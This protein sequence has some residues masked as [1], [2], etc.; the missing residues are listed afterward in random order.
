MKRNTRKDP[1]EKLNRKANKTR[2]IFSTYFDR[3]ALSFE[4]LFILQKNHFSTL[5]VHKRSL[6]DV[7]RC[8]RGSGYWLLAFA[9][10]QLDKLVS[11]DM[12]RLQST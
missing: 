4:I 6:C 10:I 2:T 12:L 5:Q 3:E 8:C 9:F 7:K 1:D 11:L